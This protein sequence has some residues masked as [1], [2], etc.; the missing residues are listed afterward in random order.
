MNLQNLQSGNSIRCIYNTLSFIIVSQSLR[1]NLGKAF[2][3]F[4]QVVPL[5]YEPQNDI[6]GSNEL[7]ASLPFQAIIAPSCAPAR[8]LPKLAE[9]K[10]ICPTVRLRVRSA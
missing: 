1:D 5:V 9:I 2:C 7:V 10:R 4:F 6:A 3:N 8:S